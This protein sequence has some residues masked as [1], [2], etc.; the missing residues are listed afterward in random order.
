[1]TELEKMAGGQIYDAAG[2]RELL[3]LRD[4]CKDLC[5]RFNQLLPSQHREQE[6]LLRQIFASAGESPVVTAPFWCDYGFHIT[7][8]DNFYANHN[9]VIL[10]TAPVT[11]GHNVMIGPNCCFAAAAHPLDLRRRRAGLEFSRPIVVGD[12]VWFGANVTVLPGVTIG[13]GSIIGAG[14]VVSRDIPAGVIA[15]GTPCRPVRPI[16]AEEEQEALR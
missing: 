2:S 13:A 7:V 11:F 10:D 14:S 15:V 4:R 5:H 8:G 9:C 12:D 3:E 6:E 1:M 16:P